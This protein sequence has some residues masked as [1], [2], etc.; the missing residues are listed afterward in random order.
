MEYD[1]TNLNDD[2]Y[3]LKY[4][5]YA[6]MCNGTAVCQGYSNLLYRMLLEAGVDCRIISGIGVSGGHAWNI[7]RLGDLYYNVDA[8]WDSNYDGP[9]N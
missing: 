5:A 1:Y 6:A 3:K 9:D 7:V 2:N 8:T 4:T